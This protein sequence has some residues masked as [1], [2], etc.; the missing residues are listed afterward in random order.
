M[1]DFINQ[2]VRQLSL[3]QKMKANI[4]IALLHDPD[5]LYLD[6]PTIGLDV[7]S[8]KVLREALKNINAEKSTTMIL[9]KYATG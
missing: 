3:G 9:K 7:T 1:K 6:E 4:A 8:K 5:V 2:P